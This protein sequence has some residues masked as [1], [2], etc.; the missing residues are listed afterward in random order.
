M[1]DLQFFGE[2]IERL[3]DASATSGPLARE[4]SEELVRLVVELYGAGLERVMEVLHAA[5]ALTDSVLEQLVDDEL[6]A[7][8]LLVHDLHPYGVQER[9]Q[10]ALDGVRPY[11]GSHGGDVEL[12]EVVAADSATPEDGAPIHGA[13][14]RLR[15]LGSCDGCP[16][17]SATLSLAVEGAIHQAAPEVV[18]IDVEAAT[19]VVTPALISA[20]S[21]RVRLKEPTAGADWFP[22]PVE[23]LPT[24]GVAPVTV[25]GLD[26]VLCRVVGT[27]FAYRDSCPSC[28]ASLAGGALERGLGTPLGTAVLTCPTC[29]AHYD[30]T[31]AG[32][33]TAGTLAHLDPLPLLE[34]NGV[35]EVAVPRPVPA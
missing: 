9:V 29:R 24:S 14:V 7:G 30:V 3:L 5:G 25:G 32:V 12:V 11:L 1:T 17:S 31:K 18:R 33:G 22:L 35:V 10:R 21:L 34:R 16:S 2:R 27:L 20:D 26:L 15:M 6:V 4:R 19:A 13:V 23:L 28:L 8:L